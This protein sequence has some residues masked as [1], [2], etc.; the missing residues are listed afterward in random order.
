LCGEAKDMQI[1]IAP[2]IFAKLEDRIEVE[3]VSDLILKGFQRPIPSY[4]VL[5]ARDEKR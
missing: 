1:L 4:N 5:A 2:R 3:P